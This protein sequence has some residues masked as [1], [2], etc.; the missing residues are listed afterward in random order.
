[1][2]EM[3]MKQ[4]VTKTLLTGVAAALLTACSSMTLIPT[5]VVV[6][7]SAPDGRPK[8]ANSTKILWEENNFVHLR[9]SHT[10]KGDER[11][12][13]CYDLARFDA[14]ESLLT[15]LSVSIKGAID[16]AQQ[17]L[18]ESAELI[19]GK[20]RSGEFKGTIRGLR[21]TEQFHERYVIGEAERV[22]CFVLA[23]MK[24]RDYDALRLTL[25]NDLAAADPKL[26]EAILKKQIKFFD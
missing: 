3:N 24:K 13:G 15:E 9:A 11:V 25:L 4:N 17:S 21:M 18:S 19:L 26:K 2:E 1:M 12:N 7:T 6:D 8:W 22:D 5:K 20:V 10:V 16:N 23:E 14:Q